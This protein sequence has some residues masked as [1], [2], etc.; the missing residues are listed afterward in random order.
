MIACDILCVIKIDVFLKKIINC[1][2]YYTLF[3]NW[4][5]NTFSLPNKFLYKKKKKKLGF[6]I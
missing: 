2:I 6:Y 5:L 4:K 3:Y 1:P